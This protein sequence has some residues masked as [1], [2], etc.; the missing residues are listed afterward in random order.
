MQEVGGSNPP[1]STSEV[2]RQR[3][4]FGIR[5][6]R[7]GTRQPTRRLLHPGLHPGRPALHLHME[8]QPGR[9]RRWAPARTD[10]SR[11]PQRT[12]AIRSSQARLRRD[13][14]LAGGSGIPR[15]GHRRKA[16]ERANRPAVRWAHPE[17]R[18]FVSEQE[19]VVRVVGT[20]GPGCV[21]SVV[22]QTLLNVLRHEEHLG[23]DIGPGAAVPEDEVLG[24]LASPSE[25]GDEVCRYQ[26]DRSGHRPSSEA[27]I[28][29]EDRQRGGGSAPGAKRSTSQRAPEP[30][31]VQTPKGPRD[32]GVP[33]PLRCRHLR[34][35]AVGH[36]SDLPAP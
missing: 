23:D 3:G 5:R 29:H 14:H 21:D 26:L 36:C 20:R 15:S 24:L 2:P 30:P 35:V 11:H 19:R 6:R 34:S 31:P 32:G 12:Q 7:P 27:S 8:P 13:R 4:L 10:F 22:V 28:C 25:G 33:G 17:G 16:A 1:G 9:R 18:K